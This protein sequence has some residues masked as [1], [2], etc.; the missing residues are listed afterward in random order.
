MFYNRDHWEDVALPEILMEVFNEL[1]EEDKAKKIALKK[2]ITQPKKIIKKKP[3]KTSSKSLLK[4][5]L[6]VN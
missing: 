5:L 2:S 4:K 1:N 6:G 3:N